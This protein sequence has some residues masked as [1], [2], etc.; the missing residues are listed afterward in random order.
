MTEEHVRSS[1]ITQLM[2]RKVLPLLTPDHVWHPGLDKE[3][4][5][6][7]ENQ[8]AD[9]R[10]DG[11]QSAQAWKAALHL[12]NDSL[13]AAHELVQ[14]LETPT[15]SALHGIMH[16]RESDFDNAK[17]WFHRAGDHPAFHSL[18]SRV[19]RF[20]AEQD[21]PIGILSE[22]LGQIEQQGSW[23][24]YLFTNAVAIVENRI[25]D[26]AARAVLEQLQQ[27]ELEALIRYLEGRISL[28]EAI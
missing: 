3:I 6:L 23:N 15:G 27:L 12:W 2:S 11:I 25:G 22:V 14:E 10:P 8:L 20:L 7:S 9:G 4:A 16:R 28:H 26:D 21:Q 13:D 24:P 18:Q 5:A 19:T 1:V 17:Y